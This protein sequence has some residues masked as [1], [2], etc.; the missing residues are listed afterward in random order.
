MNTNF[1]YFLKLDTLKDLLIDLN[2]KATRS[3]LSFTTS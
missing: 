2:P 3:E 1:D